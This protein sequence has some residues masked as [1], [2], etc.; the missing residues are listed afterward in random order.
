MTAG[1]A[2]TSGHHAAWAELLR[3]L[4]V[5]GPLTLEDLA[6]Y[7]GFHKLTVGHI[8]RALR[9]RALVHVA[10]WDA[11]ARGRHNVPV[12]AWGDKPDKKRPPKAPR[13]YPNR[14][15][16]ISILTHLGAP[17]GPRQAA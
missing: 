12:W 16:S 15:K 2:A 17:D 14:R 13:R 7:S 11:D 4:V 8:V 1:R 3:A 10:E 6:E 9:A 5:S